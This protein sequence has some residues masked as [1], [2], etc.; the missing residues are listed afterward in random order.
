MRKL[1]RTPLW[2]LLQPLYHSPPVQRVAGR[3]IRRATGFTAVVGEDPPR[4]ADRGPAP[5]TREDTLRRAYEASEVANEPDTFVLYRIVGND[6]A[7]RHRKGQSRENVRF[8]LDNEPELPGCEKRWI[9]NRIVDPEEDRAIRELLESRG[10]AYVHIPYSRDEYARQGWDLAGLPRPGYLLSQTFDAM[11]D[12]FRSR[13]SKR[14]YRHKNNYVANNNGARNVALEDGRGR[15]KWVLPWD[16]NCFL[17]EHAWR[18]L[19]EAVTA[20]PWYPYAI[21]PMARTNDHARILEPRFEPVAREEPQVLFRRDAAER[22]NPE[23]YYGRRPKIELLWRLGVPGAWDEWAIEPWDLP[24]PD[25]CADA[26]AWH[27]AGWVVRLPSGNAQAEVG[28]GSRSRRLF[29]RADALTGF[30]RRL[31]AE[32]IERHA[33]SARPLLFFEESGIG[34]RVT[35]ESESHLAQLLSARILRRRSRRA[36]RFAVARARRFLGSL[37]EHVLSLDAAVAP[38]LVPLLRRLVR[39]MLRDAGARSI[40]RELGADGTWYELT[41]AT[42]LVALRDWEA[43]S[44]RLVICADRASVLF[45]SAAGTQKALA[46]DRHRLAWQVLDRLADRCGETLWYAAARPAALKQPVPGASLLWYDE[47]EVE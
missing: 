23:Y 11:P 1:A 16:G 25:Y 21:V 24:Y 27:E 34:R 5:R 9:V 15:A 47:P 7:P 46:D 39:W 13:L 19:V 2:A 42:I 28:L 6:L 10:Q 3:I 26:G 4:A 14:L 29:L 32:L 36:S 33:E 38:E 17:T 31:D 12:E 41:L 35:L 43:L 45:G 22:F 30:L 40:R 18:K 8:I 20:K 44:L 37:R